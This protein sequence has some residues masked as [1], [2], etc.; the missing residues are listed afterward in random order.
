MQNVVFEKISLRNVRCHEHM[1]MEFPMGQF[2]VLVGKNGQ[3]K[4]TVY[5]AISMA[6][7]GD[8]GAKEGERA[9]ISDMVNNKVGKDFEIIFTFLVDE[10]RYRIELYY[11]HKKQ[12][13]NMFLFRND[14]DISGA[15]KSD[16]Y[17]KI[18]NILV[19]RDV[20]HNIVYF[21]QQVKDFFTSLTNSK[22]K[23]IFDAI[24][25]LYEYE[26]YYKRTDSKMKELSIS[27]ESEDHR[28]VV[29]EASIP[30]QEDKLKM[31]EDIKGSKEL[32]NDRNIIIRQSKEAFE[33]KEIWELEQEKKTLN[34]DQKEIDKWTSQKAKLENQKELLEA[35]EAK[36]E[37]QVVEERDQLLST[38]EKDSDAVLSKTKNEIEVNFNDRQEEVNGSIKSILQQMSSIQEKFDTTS[39]DHDFEEFRKEK[40][41]ETSFIYNEISALDSQ[42][43]T[44]ELFDDKSLRLKSLFSKKDEIQIKANQL[45]VKVQK[46]EFDIE[47]LQREINTDKASLE[48]ESPICPKCGRKLDEEHKE[49]IRK[50]LQGNISCLE[51]LIGHL[52]DYKRQLIQAREECGLADQIIES[53]TK[54]FDDQ[55]KSREDK[56]TKEREILQRKLSLIE[57]EINEVRT[58]RDVFVQEMKSKIEEEKRKLLKQKQELED[59]I[60]FMVQHKISEILNAEEKAQ[61]DLLQSKEE[62]IK[63]FSELIQQKLKEVKDQILDMEKLFEEADQM[64]RSL[65]ENKNRVDEIEKLTFSK[66]ETIKSLQ[67]E[68]KTLQNF[69]YDCSKILETSQKIE[70]VKKEK[71]QIQSSIQ[72]V[73][74]EMEILTFW[75]EAFSDRGIKSMLIDSAVPFMNRV[76]REELDRVAPGVFTVSFDTLSTTKGGEIRDKFSV[77]VLHNIKGTDQHKLLSGGEK[78]LIDLCCMRALK[79][80]AENLYQKKFFVT[81]YDEVLDSLDDDNSFA[82][83]QLMKIVSSDQHVSLI[84]HELLDNVEADQVYRF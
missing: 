54:K 6:L 52:D 47:K 18:K 9:S 81:L 71:D 12:H 43:S 45:D 74:R 51:I 16:T 14:I 19:P 2:S 29:L 39:K 26:T 49:K 60:S 15:T 11:K 22:Q 72:K 50:E 27:I 20:Y 34:F 28:M 17:E 13:N 46:N 67:S 80:L 8:D 5:K 23:E 57:S 42:Y 73:K 25:D 41:K 82:F 33:E 83:C 3:G 77:N 32:E 36:I 76:V 61:K 4:S 48:E 65:L 31:M 21:N 58:K 35:S 10:N 62:Q 1:E 63:K 75:K 78:R 66:N 24:L 30:E 64:L 55:I 40:E 44:I 68:I 53:D 56:K 37:G 79:L 59:K 69:T 70:T 38:L 84:T 7:Y